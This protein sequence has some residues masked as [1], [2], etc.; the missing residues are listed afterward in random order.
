[1]KYRF[2]PRLSR[3]GWGFLYFGRKCGIIGKSVG[4]EID[5]DAGERTEK[6]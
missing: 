1:M 4:A 5:R 2:M 6:S 3:D